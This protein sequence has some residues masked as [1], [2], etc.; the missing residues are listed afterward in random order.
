MSLHLVDVYTPIVNDNEQ[1]SLISLLQIE[2]EMLDCS[3]SALRKLVLHDLRDFGYKLCVENAGIG[4]S[5]F[6]A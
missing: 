4:N 5:E 6:F 3:I 1:Q 2:E